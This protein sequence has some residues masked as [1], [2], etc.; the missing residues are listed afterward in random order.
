MRNTE[1][2]WPRLSHFL[3]GVFSFSAFYGCDQAASTPQDQWTD[4]PGS[5]GISG[6]AAVGGPQ[7]G[8]P[9]QGAGT[10]GGAPPTAGGSGGTGGTLPTG[11][12]G[13]AT[14]PATGGAGGEIV[15]IDAG[16]AGGAGGSVPTGGSNGS[17]GTASSGGAGGDIAIVDAGTVDG[18]AGFGGASGTGG[19][20]DADGTSGSG[21]TSGTGGTGGS[22]ALAGCEV[23]AVPDNIRSSYGLDP[24]YQKYADA[25]GIPVATSSLVADEAITLACQLIKEMVSL[26]DDVR[27]ALINAGM[28]FTLI[29]SSEQLS[30]IPEINRTYGSMYDM[31]ARGL[32]SIIPTIC[33]EENILCQ[34]S[35]DRWRGENICVHEYAHTML[36]YGL[37]RADPTF[38]SRLD[39]AYRTAQATGNFANTYAISKV[40]D[41]WAEGVQDWYNSNLEAIPTNGIH[42][43]VNTR[44][45]LLEASPELYDLIAEWLP[46][47]IQFNDCYAVQ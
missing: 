11:G 10:S 15:S 41:F 4:Q 31:R 6:G 25:N 45:E 8:F 34:V 24:F 2:K 12:S 26:R 3:L 35:V 18:A 40:S 39:A 20:S 42:N 23:T 37:A 30:S 16:I 9:G 47:D 28:R 17:S 22:D 14:P 19:T 38:R 13:G 21:D 1:R 32:G 43:S 7:A 33:A 36:D 5:G 44:D 46:E 29:A 27:Q